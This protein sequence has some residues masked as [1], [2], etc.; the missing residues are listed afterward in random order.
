[1]RVMVFVKATPDSEKGLPPTAEMTK[2]LRSALH[3]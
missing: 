3:P 2:L 1:M